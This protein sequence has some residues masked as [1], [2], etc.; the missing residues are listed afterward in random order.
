MPR[1]SR[2]Y[3]VTSSIGPARSAG[4]INNSRPD[5]GWGWVVVFGSFFIS[6]I[7]DG[8]AY[9]T[10]IFYEQFLHIYGQSESVTSLFTS[11]MTG[12]FSVMG[13]VAAGLSQTYGCRIVTLMGSM[14]ATLSMVLS[15]VFDQSMYYHILTLGLGCGFG[16][17]LIYLPQVTIVTDWFEK[18]ISLATGISVAGSGFGIA[19]FA[20]FSTEMFNHYDWHTVMLFLAGIMFL[21]VFFALTFSTPPTGLS[22]I[23]EEKQKKAKAS[24]SSLETVK[25][26]LRSSCNFSMLRE[27]PFLY[28]ILSNALAS[29]VY[30]IPFLISSD[31]MVRAGFGTAA[32]GLMLM[33]YFGISNGFARFIV[34]YIADLPWVNRTVFFGL[35]NMTMGV[36]VALT[37]FA[38]NLS[39]MNILYVLLGIADGKFNTT[40]K[41]LNHFLTCNLFYSNSSIHRFCDSCRSVWSRESLQHLWNISLIRRHGIHHWST[42]SQ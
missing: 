25:E 42:I 8:F 12:I 28:L 21:C 31:R 4:F 9:T 37:T 39:S 23:E 33:V 41:F 13:P 19:L 36:L 26:A 38:N 16:F 5:G 11:L 7:T 20:Y 3:S 40:S 34:G 6:F 27:L 35:S 14:I 18:R 1:L 2:S 32:D 10:G 15:V 29:L 17:G 30:Y 22:S 24:V